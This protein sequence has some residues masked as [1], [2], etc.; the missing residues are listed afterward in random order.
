MSAGI[1]PAVL[2]F[3]DRH[4]H[5]IEQL[6]ILLLVHRLKDREW[7]ARAVADELRSNPDSAAQRLR[8]LAEDGLVVA[9]DGSPDV[10]RYRATGDL[11]R[12]VVALADAY[13]DY[14]LRITER[15]FSKPDGLTSF[16][17]AFRFRRK[18]E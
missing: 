1:D 7:T 17:D 15:V 6:E 2:A 11:D 10:Y 18:G 13:R 3:V 5:S 16:A 4:I 8:E 12:A 9:A 14:R